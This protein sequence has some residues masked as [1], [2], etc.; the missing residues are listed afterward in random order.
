MFEL[1]F[2]PLEAQ[3]FALQKVG[4]HQLDDLLLTGLTRSIVL[5][6]NVLTNYL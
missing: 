1:L 2:I 6:E 4:S 3:L 5:L